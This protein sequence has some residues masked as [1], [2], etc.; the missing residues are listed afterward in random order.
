MSARRRSLSRRGSDSPRVDAAGGAD[1]DY[2]ER[3]LR[4]LRRR[5]L[6]MA[7]PCR[8]RM[9]ARKPCLRFRRRLFGWNVRF[10]SLRPA[11]EWKLGGSR[12]VGRSSRRERDG[13]CAKTP[14]LTAHGAIGQGRAPEPRAVGAARRSPQLVLRSSRGRSSRATRPESTST[15]GTSP[16]A[17]SK[18]NRHPALDDPLLMADG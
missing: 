7:R 15:V 18:R 14:K 8:V 9:R 2:A 13:S 10:T 11:S 6:R 17:T 1:I 5:R 4:P 3:R 12:S 16:T